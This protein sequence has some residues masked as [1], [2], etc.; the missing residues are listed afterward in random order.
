MDLKEIRDKI[1]EVDDQLLECFIKRMELSYEVAKAKHKEGLIIKN[2]SRE[3]EILDRVTKNAGE[4]AP[5]AR[6]LYSTLFDLSK[7][8]Q[9]EFLLKSQELED[10]IKEAVKNTPE[11][12]PKKG[13]IAVQGTEGSY[14]QQASDKLFPMGHLMY[15]DT[16][17]SVFDAVEQGLCDYGVL[18]IENSSN[19]SV[20]EVYELMEKK[21]FS[22][23][24]SFRLF[25]HHGLLGKKG[26]KKEDIKEIISHRQAL[27]QCSGYLKKIS[28]VEIT[29][30]RNTAMA[31][32]TVSESDRKELAAISSLHCVELYGLEVI[33]DGIQNSDNNY[34]RFICISKKLEIYPGANKISIMLTASHEPGGLYKIIA[35]FAS[36]GLN[37]TKIES[38]SIVGRDFEF[39]FH[40]DFEGSVLMPEVM[41]LLSSL[42]KENPDFVFLG[43]YSET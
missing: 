33:E 14:S 37:L 15:F 36:L 32:K 41:G 18:P 21:N 4:F 7:S 23:I 9:S 13:M 2:K 8:Y 20:K 31:A 11:L 26:I 24:S 16:F 40:F 3:R 38:R 35:R 1:N 12:L 28:D 5:Y 25:I 6:L 30:V 19:G 27:E 22:I 34:T 10:Q 42:K 29:S 43:N 17:E 39:M